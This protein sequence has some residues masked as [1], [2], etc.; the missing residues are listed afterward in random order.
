MCDYSGNRYS[1]LIKDDV[2]NGEGLGAVFF[3][4]GC[5][6]NNTT[7][8]THHCKNCHNP[9]TWDYNG[10]KPLT[11]EVINSIWDY[12]D[13]TPFAT[14]LT[15]T[16]GEPF[17]LNYPLTVSIVREF[18][19][20]YPDK[21][22][23]AY[24]GFNMGRITFTNEAINR[25]YWVLAPPWYKYKDSKCSPEC[26]FADIAKIMRP[27]FKDDLI[28]FDIIVD[29]DYQHDKRDLTL[30]FRGSSNQRLIDIKKTIENGEITL[31]EVK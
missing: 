30:P 14:R 22:V 24:T 4:Q 19:K 9:Q 15:I 18:K 21:K 25:F 12:F 10:G 5:S 7:T 23:W 28:Y 27:F 17:D 13:N 2:A 26:K 8:D 1:G 20:R 31:Y 3:V 16:G 29:G 11:V 6:H